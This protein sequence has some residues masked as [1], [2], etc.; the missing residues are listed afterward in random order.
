M[1]TGYVTGV[2]HVGPPLRP[3]GLQLGWQK[4]E[5]QAYYGRP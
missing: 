4:V 5:Y 2:E 1:R 3:P